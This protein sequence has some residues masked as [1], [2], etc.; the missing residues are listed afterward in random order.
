[1]HGKQTARA[2]ILTTADGCCAFLPRQVLVVCTDDGKL[3]MTNGK[4]FNSGHAATELFLPLLHFKAA[5]FD[6]EFA[7]VSG[8]AVVIE[9]WGFP[10]KDEAVKGLY[11]ELKPKLEAPKKLEDVDLSLAGYAGIYLPGGHGA[12]VNLPESVALGKLLHAA[13]AAA[14]PTIALCHGPAGLLAAG[15]VPGAKSP[16]EG[17]KVVSFPDKVDVKTLPAVGYLPGPMPWLVQDKLRELGFVITNTA[18]K[19]ATLVDRELIT[20]DGVSASNKLGLVAAPI[21]VAAW[22]KRA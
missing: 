8:G 15:K 17:Y 16:Y 13:N 19:G 10:Q 3:K 22:S 7:T 5:G 20:G 6:F 14:L 2:T 1:L 4:A 11:E 21:L 18:E 12:M 9:M